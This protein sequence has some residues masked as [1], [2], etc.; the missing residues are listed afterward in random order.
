MGVFF[1]LQ[2]RS[3]SRNYGRQFR[4]FPAVGS[5]MPNRGPRITVIAAISYQSGLLSLEMNRENFD[6]RQFTEFLLRNLVPSLRLYNGINP[7]SVVVMGM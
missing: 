5:Y 7:N 1:Y 3:I 6:G 2:D 4:G